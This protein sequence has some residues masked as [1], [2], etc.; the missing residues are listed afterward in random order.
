MVCSWCGYFNRSLI[1]P[2][3]IRGT[4]PQFINQTSHN[5]RGPLRSNLQCTIIPSTRSKPRSV[6]LTKIQNKNHTERFSKMASNP[7]KR[8]INGESSREVEVMVSFHGK[9]LFACPIYSRAD[10]L[11]ML[12]YNYEYCEE[13]VVD[14]KPVPPRVLVC[15]HDE[16]TKSISTV[17]VSWM[18]WTRMSSIV[19]IASLGTRRAARTA[20]IVWLEN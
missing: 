1:L 10:K 14:M 18:K 9:F 3:F 6:V 4:R 11:R 12:L 2:I 8:K 5:T 15:Q 13:T 19:F 17:L 7:K 20:A 16:V